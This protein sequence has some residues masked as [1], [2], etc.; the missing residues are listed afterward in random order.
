MDPDYTVSVIGK[1]VSM[2]ADNKPAE[3]ASYIV[4]QPERVNVNSEQKKRKIPVKYIGCAVA[5]AVAIVLVCSRYGVEKKASANEKMVTEQETAVSVQNAGIR[6]ETDKKGGTSGADEQMHVV[7]TEC[8]DAV[9]TGQGTV[10]ATDEGST[11]F[12]IPDGATLLEQLAKQEVGA[13]YEETISGLLWNYELIA[14]IRSRAEAEEAEEML[15]E[16]EYR[17]LLE[18]MGIPKDYVSQDPELPDYL[19]KTY[20]PLMDIELSEEEVV[21]LM[22]L[23]EA[24]APAEDIYGKILVANVVLNRVNS[25]KMANTV[26]GVIYE[27]IDGNTQFSPTAISW[28]WNSIV[29][30]DSTREAVA[31]C[32]SGEDYSDGAL[33]FYAWERNPNKHKTSEWMRELE[34]LFT[35]GGHRFF[36]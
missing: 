21:T 8:D 23:V 11:A 36:R 14:D 24:E 15:R 20:N 2:N 6:Q 1:D 13:D 32:L 7:Q 26:T 29:V 27:K 25:E 28:Y 10:P 33:Y 34:C 22:R 31:R 5:A 18:T 4:R 35:H 3:M 17:E 19:T 9:Q 12:V 30:T 16:E